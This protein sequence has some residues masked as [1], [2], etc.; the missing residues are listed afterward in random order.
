MLYEFGNFRLDTDVALTANGEET[1]VEPQVFTLLQY[2]VEHREEVVSKDDLITHVWDG[3]IVSDAAIPSAINLARRAAGD[4][5]RAQAVIKTFPR[6]GFKFVVG[7]AWA[8]VEPDRP[9]DEYSCCGSSE[10]FSKGRTGFCF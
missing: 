10:I 7:L 1:A 3:R 2:L 9:D 6:R 4:D 8:C 5:G